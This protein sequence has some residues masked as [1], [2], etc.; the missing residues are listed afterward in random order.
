MLIGVAIGEQGL[1]HV[2]EHQTA[3][4]V[5]ALTLFVLHDAALII[6]LALRHR[7]QQVA[8]AV[9]FQPQ[10]ALQG[11]AGDG[12][13]VIGAVEPRRAV[14]IGRAHFREVLEV[15]IRRVFRAVEHQVF[16]QVG[17]AGLAFRLVLGADIVPYRH[18]DDRRLAV[19]M[20]QHG[21]AVCQLELLIGDRHLAHESRQIGS[22]LR[23]S[24]GGRRGLGERGGER[25]GKRKGERRKAGGGKTVGHG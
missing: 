5:I 10:R 25:H 21:E 11:G 18:V 13:E 20:H 8:H 14:V 16:E 22:C 2:V 23:G 3:R 19:F 7:T 24:A 1:E 12:L 17:K 15:V 6:E 9:A 4:L